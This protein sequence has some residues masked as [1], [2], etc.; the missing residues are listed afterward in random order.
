[1]AISAWARFENEKVKI[2]GWPCQNYHPIFDIKLL[3]LAALSFGLLGIVAQRF[4]DVIG[5][6][7]SWRAGQ[8][9]AWLCYGPSP[10]NT[11]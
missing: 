4:G 8:S 11:D 2:D 7:S 10:R 3:A 1:M 6:F 5:N 9:Q